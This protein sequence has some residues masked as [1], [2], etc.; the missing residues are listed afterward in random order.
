MSKTE[1]WLSGA[2]VAGDAAGFVP[3]YGAIGATTSFLAGIAR[4]A[5]DGDGKVKWGKHAL[6]LGFIG[7]SALG[8]GATKAAVKGLGLAT[9]A[10]DKVVDTAKAVDKLESALK[11]S[12][13]ASKVTKAEELSK[14]SEFA[15]LASDIE[16]VK[17]LDKIKKTGKSFKGAV[18]ELA[19][20]NKDEISKIMNSVDNVITASKTPTTIT[21]QLGKATVDS[22]KGLVSGT[23][24]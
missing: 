5:I 12:K 8:L 17:E 22:A 4:D 19:E 11:T 13:G 20:G 24:K 2:E 14:F 15:N 21:G 6:N 18:E 23:G 7:A 16:K 3:V 10:A 9:K 1:R